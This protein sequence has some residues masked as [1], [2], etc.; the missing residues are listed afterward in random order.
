MGHKMSMNRAFFLKKEDRDPRW[1]VFD[2]TGRVL[3]RFAT[4]IA[5]I[6]R[7]KDKVEYTPH[8]DAGDYVIVI[9]AEKIKLTGDKWKKKEYRRYTG[10]MGG[11]KVL[12]ARQMLEK[13][14]TKIITQAVHGM[15]P[16]NKL[17]R[18]ILKKLKVYTGETHPHK[19]QVE[20]AEQQQ[21]KTA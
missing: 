17:N 14:P 10:W 2:A 3:G 13:H 4:E 9:N 12:S 19:A 5:D 6:L 15:L 21:G 20:A 7:G 8:T 1:K 16:K 18:E 11:Y